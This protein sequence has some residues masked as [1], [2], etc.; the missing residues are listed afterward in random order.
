VRAAR[1]DHDAIGLETVQL[2]GFTF[3]R[4][5][6][7]VVAHLAQQRAGLVREHTRE[8]EGLDLGAYLRDRLSAVVRRGVERGIGITCVAGAAIVATAREPTARDHERC[9]VAMSA[10]QKLSHVPALRPVPGRCYRRLG[11]RQPQD[12]AVRRLEER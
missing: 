6:R 12:R 11:G 1:H 2:G 7:A 5:L 3:E 8:R 4:E 9:C 10:M